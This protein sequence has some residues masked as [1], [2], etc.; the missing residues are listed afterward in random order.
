MTAESF[1]HPSIPGKIEPAL[2]KRS[3]DR[4]PERAFAIA[5]SNPLPRLVSQQV[6]IRQRHRWR[7]SILG[8][9]GRRPEKVAATKR[10]DAPRRRPVTPERHMPKAWPKKFVGKLDFAALPKMRGGYRSVDPREGDRPLDRGN[11]SPVAEGRGDMWPAGDLAVQ[12]EVGRNPG[13]RRPA[14]RKNDAVARRALAA[15]SWRGRH[16]CL[17]PSPRRAD[18]KIDGQDPLQAAMARLSGS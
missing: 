1:R 10:R 16:L 11:L 17:A 6:S 5:A 13:T 14:D 4:Y 7:K 12:I 8:R 15:P 2:P 18:L 3:P 9:R